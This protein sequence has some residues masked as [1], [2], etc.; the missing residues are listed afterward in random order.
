MDASLEEAI[1]Y[2]AETAAKLTAR[3]TAVREAAAIRSRDRHVARHGARDP[4]VKVGDMVILLH[5]HAEKNQKATYK[6]AFRSQVFRVH[7]VTGM[8][9]SR[10]VYVTAAKGDVVPRFKQPLNEKR[11]KKVS[12][13]LGNY[14]TFENTPL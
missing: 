9:P 12:P 1:Q 2:R 13:A 8:L 14:L 11:L 6:S 10:R 4:D 7:G 5:L 3:I